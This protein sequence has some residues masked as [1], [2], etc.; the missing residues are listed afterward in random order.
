[1]N[2]YQELGPTPV[3]RSITG[4]PED[5]CKCEVGMS[6]S[7]G[8]SPFHAEWQ[9]PA[10]LSEEVAQDQHLFS[11]GHSLGALCCNTKSVQNPG[12]LIGINTS[13]LLSSPGLHCALSEDRH[14]AGF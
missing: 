7:E 1:M 11:G 4:C 3:A 14:W 9:I 10:Y 6:Q 8:M 2:H 13:L 5:D 12:G